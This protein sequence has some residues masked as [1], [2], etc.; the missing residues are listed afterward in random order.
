MLADESIT[1]PERSYGIDSSRI[2]EEVME[3]KS[4]NESVDALLSKLFRLIDREDFSSARQ[5]LPQIEAEL[6]P[7]DPEVTRARTLMA[8]LEDTP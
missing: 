5:V 3:A 2:L 6:G 7:N 4:R 8:F 1:V